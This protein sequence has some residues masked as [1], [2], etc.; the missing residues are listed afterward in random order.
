MIKI[1]I[2][3]YKGKKIESTFFMQTFENVRVI[4]ADD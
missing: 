1:A 4:Y 2:I 3:Y